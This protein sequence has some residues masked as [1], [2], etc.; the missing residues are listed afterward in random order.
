MFTLEGKQYA[1]SLFDKSVSNNSKSFKY[2]IKL[3]A[4]HTVIAENIFMPRLVNKK[5]PLSAGYLSAHYTEFDPE[6]S[7]CSG[8]FSA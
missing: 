4:L 5:K 2:F 8:D 7:H 1:H 3:N 6:P